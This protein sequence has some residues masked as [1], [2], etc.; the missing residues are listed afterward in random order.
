MRKV[1]R[2]FTLGDWKMRFF[3]LLAPA[4]F[5]A[6]PAQSQVSVPCGGSFSSFLKNVRAEALSQ[7]LPKSAVDRFL[8]GAAQ[9]S[10]TLSRDRGQGHDPDGPGRLCSRKDDGCLG[11]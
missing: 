7:G 6:L 9:D 3:K 1:S 11:R 4:L 10:R 2:D 5:A 8:Q